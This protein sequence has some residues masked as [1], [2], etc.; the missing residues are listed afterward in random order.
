VTLRG[1]S[2]GVLD[3]CLFHIPIVAPS[4]SGVRPGSSPK[5]HRDI[6]EPDAEP[7]FPAGVYD[8]GRDPLTL[9]GVT[10]AV[11]RSNLT[12]G[13]DI[14]YNPDFD[15]FHGKYV[16]PT[17]SPTAEGRRRPG[18]IWWSTTRGRTPPPVRDALRVATSWIHLA[19]RYLSTGPTPAYSHSTPPHFPLGGP[20]LT[21]PVKGTSSRPRSTG[22]T[23]SR[24]RGRSRLLCCGSIQVRQRNG[25]NICTR[26]GDVPAVSVPR[27]GHGRDSTVTRHLHGIARPFRSEG[28]HDGLT[29]PATVSLDAIF[30]N[31]GPDHVRD[32]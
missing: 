15:R 16:S 4:P 5:R 18:Q 25:I 1:Q 17:P 24:P 14:N 23:A 19:P 3:Y 31:V 11:A 12:S 29:T 20:L 2:D 26:C 6:P 22:V 10:W 30:M 28:G 27:R 8:S 7:V 32:R 21:V 9:V 13:G